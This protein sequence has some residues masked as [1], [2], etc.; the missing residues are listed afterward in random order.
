[1]QSVTQFSVPHIPEG[2]AWD[3]VGRKIYW[4]DTENRTIEVLD[5]AT[6][7]HKTLINTGEGSKPRAI[8]VDP[9]QG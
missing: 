6:G 7:F 8:V 1:M 3:W 9:L 4:T 2:L 5:P